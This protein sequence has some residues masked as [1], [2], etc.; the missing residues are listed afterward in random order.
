MQ[1]RSD[2]M[3]ARRD[4][5][6]RLKEQIRAIEDCSATGNSGGA[7]GGDGRLDVATGWAEVDR[8]LG[9]EQRKY[10]GLGRGVI[11]E[12]FGVDHRAAGSA[13]AQCR[14]R[15][16]W[17]PPLCLLTHL[18][19]QALTQDD[20]GV[21]WIGRH[22]WPHPRVLIRDHD[23]GGQHLLKRSIFAD[24]PNAGVRL[25]AIDLALRS[26]AVT[27]IVAD[28]ST[29]DLRATRRLQLAA[30]SSRA[31]ALLARPPHELS[32]L[33]AAATRWL[34]RTDGSGGRHVRQHGLADLMNTLPRWTIELRRCKSKQAVAHAVWR[35]VLEWHR[36]NFAVPVS[37]EL[38]DRP[39]QTPPRLEEHAARKTA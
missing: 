3:Q 17:A 31:L 10:C 37:A 24:P 13:Q 34:V 18:V 15:P 39:D 28:G 27:A 32:H 22:C 21:L 9:D 16:P 36:G 6:R 26:T 20:G 23:R 29:L 4:L 2:L 38:V 35:W 14:R 8:A 12:W 19:W 1:G 33:S 11:H 25:W 7:A 5:V 30:E